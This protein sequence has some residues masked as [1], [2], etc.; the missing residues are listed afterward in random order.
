MSLPRRLLLPFGLAAGSALLRT[1]RAFAD[2]TASPEDAAQIA[3][4]AAQPPVAE[5]PAEPAEPSGLALINAYRAAAGAPPASIH[6]AL[7]RSAEG[8]VA[9]YEAN[10]NN[11]SFNGMGLHMQEPERPGFTGKTM[12]ERAKNAGYGSGSVTE[13]AGFGTI[14][15]AVQ[16]AINTVNHR[17]PL[18]HP[19]A[20]DMGYAVSGGNG[21]GIVD[22]GLRREKL[23]VS[24]PSVFPA[25][26]AT[27]IPTS[28]DGGETPN[29]AP[30]IARPL[31]YPITVA[32]GVYQRVEWKE[33]LLLS[34]NWEPLP[35]STPFTDWMRAAAI[36]PHKPLLRGQTYTAI[37]EAIV[38]GATVRKEWQF[39]TR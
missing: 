36:V 26:G 25:E 11:P 12:G 38:D 8:H 18:I 28:W 10:P 13:N 35:I 21:F 5:V 2:Q 17:L 4:L 23:K 37:V 22:V 31:G 16:W 6:P 19:S 30:G 1:P 20:V 32:F 3:A 33:L 27:D 14:E 34:P 24:L 15:S 29:P 9:Y 7:Q 39:T